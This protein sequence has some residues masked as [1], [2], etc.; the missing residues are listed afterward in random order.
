MDELT[1]KLGRDGG[2][3][4]EDVD[5]P[6]ALVGFLEAVKVRTIPDLVGQL[7]EK[8]WVRRILVPVGLNDLVRVGSNRVHEDRCEWRRVSSVARAS[9][10]PGST[11][12]TLR[13]PDLAGAYR[14]TKEVSTLESVSE[15][16][17]VRSPS[18]F[19]VVGVCAA[20]R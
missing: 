1:I 15:I 18:D 12:R 16:V 17:G 9:P 2:R 8:R 5:A 14:S 4:E 6:R 7:E 11:L 3:V 19:R 20:K 10:E 13:L